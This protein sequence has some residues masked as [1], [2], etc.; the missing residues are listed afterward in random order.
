VKSRLHWPYLGG[1]GLLVALPLGAAIVLAF[2]EFSGVEP[3]RFVGVANIERLVSDPDARRAL[4][5]SA[6]FVVIA[7]P[8]RLTVAVGAALLLHHRRR[9]TGVGRAAVYLPSV[10]PDAALALLF[11]WLLDP[12]IGPVGRAIGGAVL[13]NPWGA[14]LAVAGMSSLQIGE[15]FVVALAVRRLIPSAIDDAAAVDGAT[16]W[17]R[18]TRVTLPLM[19][20]ALAL[21]AL[22]DVLVALQVGFLPALLLTKGGPD[23]AT[24]TIP[25]Y[26][27]QQGFRYFRLG[28]ASA[29]SLTLLV[30]TAVAVAVQYLLARRWRLI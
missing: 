24:T 12:G 28:Y 8:L 11:L 14:R 9:G 22:R 5:A 4:V 20:P 19:A 2:T 21:L 30:V 16:A 7:V 15:A 25:L 17:F 13:E 3:P 27:Y 10:V 23:T 1:L 18:T 29:L 6:W 26:I